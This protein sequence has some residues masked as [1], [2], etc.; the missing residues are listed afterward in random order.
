MRVVTPP[1][2]VGEAWQG[3]PEFPTTPEGETPL[4]LTCRH[5]LT[6]D[7]PQRTAAA[8][9]LDIFKIA[10]R[11][12]LRDAARLR[13]AP[14]LPPQEWAAVSDTLNGLEF[15]LAEAELAQPVGR[16]D[17]V[18]RAPADDP[19]DADLLMQL[20]VRPGYGPYMDYYA[21]AF[22]TAL[23]RVPGD[24]QITLVLDD[25]HISVLLRACTLDACLS[26]GSLTALA[27]VFQD[28][29][30]VGESWWSLWHSLASWPARLS[31][32]LPPLSPTHPAAMAHTIAE[33]L[34]R[35]AEDVR[36]T[37]ESRQLAADHL[38]RPLTDVAH[39][40]T[41]FANTLGLTSPA[42]HLLTTA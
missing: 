42:V 8:F 18:F 25:I 12:Q 21:H 23:R 2:A 17:R 9:A 37:T 28:R 39:A 38:R 31:E 19:D 1:P 22:A 29:P 7:H 35:Y 16:I 34:N 4:A 5:R 13:L 41:P 10:R 33:A 40:R 30:E 3:A 32:I 24:Q 36:L 20:S 26:C 14:L 11:G 15:I 27:T 6:L